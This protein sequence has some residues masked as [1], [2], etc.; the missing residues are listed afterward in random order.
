MANLQEVAW[1]V[2]C[3]RDWVDEPAPCC[4]AA[5]FGLDPALGH[6]LDGE[7]YELWAPS[8]VSY[9]MLSWR[10]TEMGLS[11]TFW[12]MAQVPMTAPSDSARPS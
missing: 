7:L 8:P 9:L 5:F 10:A 12:F 4:A 6:H 1:V 11:V 2:E 3:R